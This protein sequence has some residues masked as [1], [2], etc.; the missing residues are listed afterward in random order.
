M[1]QKHVLL[2]SSIVLGSGDGF[3]CF[4][5]TFFENGYA[6]KILVN[7]GYNPHIVTCFG[8]K[9]LKDLIKFPAA[10]MAI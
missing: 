6:L 5:G 10:R 4:C 7:G 9:G 2:L 8:H 3:E 1:S